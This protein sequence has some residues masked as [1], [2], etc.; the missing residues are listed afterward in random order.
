MDRVLS[1]EQVREADR[2]T[3]EKLGI[4]ETDLIERAGDAIVNVILSR[5][6]GGRILICLGKGN[7]AEDGKVV[8]RLLK[9]KHGFFVKTFSLGDDISLI[10]KDKYDIILDCIFGTGLNRNIEGEYA[11]IINAINQSGCYVV[12]CDIPSGLNGNNGLVM[13]C[14]V[15][16]D[17]TIAIQEYKLGYYLN[18]GP[19]FC[20]E[21]IKKDI[22]ISVWE[23]NFAKF[24]HGQD[25]NHLFQKRNRNVN[26]GNFGKVC[27]FGG[28]K[29]YP[30]SVMISYTALCGLKMGSG[31]SNIT[32]PQCVYNACALVAFENT[33]NVV[34][35]NGEHIIFDKDVLDK[36][37]KYT[38]IA[39][40]MGLKCNIETYKTL[41]YLLENYTGN[42]LIDA[43]GLN[44]LAEFGLDILKNKKCK[45]ILTP[46]VGEF[47]RLINVD[48]KEI[49]ASPIKYAKDF[50]KKY[51]VVLVLK[52][53]VSIITDGTEIFIN[54]TGCSSLAKGGSGDLLSGIILGLC[55]RANNPIESAVAGCYIFGSTGEY[56]SKEENEYTVTATDIISALP[57]VINYLI[58]N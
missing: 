21:I 50:A 37:L 46:H 17:L 20:G 33:V 40:G 15:R 1:V 51:N 39:F 36:L 43:D 54:T 5:F 31:Y 48:K 24:I 52:S 2:T 22:G 25:I 45:V 18:D 55:G 27:V 56:C 13:G 29:D 28:S 4:P 34:K 30:G 47:S 41:C 14:A 7:N 26:K 35:D 53:A 19:D 12:S 9:H 6:K 38:S 23:E 49:I 3:I 8:K 58:E 42:L 32:I 57:K 11:N 10:S 16:A 44:S